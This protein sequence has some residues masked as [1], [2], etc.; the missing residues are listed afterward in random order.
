MSVLSE[1][2]AREIRLEF[3]KNTFSCIWRNFGKAVQGEIRP[4]NITKSIAPQTTDKIQI[5]R[6][7]ATYIRVHKVDKK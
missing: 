4:L 5:A 3:F 2:C 7:K 1:N 6:S